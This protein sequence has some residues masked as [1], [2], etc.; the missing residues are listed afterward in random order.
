MA[1]AS[2][3]HTPIFFSARRNS[4]SP[5]WTTG[6]QEAVAAIEWFLPITSTNN[7]GLF[8]EVQAR[9]AELAQ[10]LEYQT[11]SA[12]A[13]ALCDAD[14]TGFYMQQGDVFHIVANDKV[15]GDFWLTSSRTRSR[16]VAARR[17]DAQRSR[18]PPSTFTTRWQTRSTRLPRTSAWAARAPTWPCRS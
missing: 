7:V 12:T 18:S 8:Q 3:A 15:E 16:G 13:G 1:S 6:G 2:R 5:H 14:Y 9:S 11:A 10:A 4:N 17:W